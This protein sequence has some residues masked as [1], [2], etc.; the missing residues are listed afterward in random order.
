MVPFYVLAT[1]GGEVL[2]TSL[3]K[4]VGLRKILKISHLTRFQIFQDPVEVPIFSRLLCEVPGTFYMFRKV[5]EALNHFFNCCEKF[6]TILILWQ[7]L[8]Y[9]GMFLELTFH[10]SWRSPVCYGKF[11][12]VLLV[13]ESL[14]YRLV[15][16]SSSS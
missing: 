14:F 3:T 4:F 12:E 15:F 7:V 11:W 2:G 13:S 16:W 10:M 9:P 1:Y 5:H 8:R 6:W